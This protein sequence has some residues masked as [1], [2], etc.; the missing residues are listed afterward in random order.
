YVIYP[1]S[2]EALMG[3]ANLQPREWVFVLA[4]AGGVSVS[5]IQIAKG[6]WRTA[7]ERSFTPK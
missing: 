3:R 5:T 4:A 1:M 6:A 2:Y 7:T